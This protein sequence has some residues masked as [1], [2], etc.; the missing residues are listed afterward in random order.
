MKTITAKELRD[1]L[2]NIVRRARAG[3]TIRVTYRSKPAFSIVPEASQQNAPKPGS[4]EAI[5]IFLQRVN[6][7][8]RNTGSPVFDPNRSIKELY[9]DML[10]ADPKYK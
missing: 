7:R 1:N 9:H 3:E 2:D 6:E 4:P 10:D 8:R 5:N